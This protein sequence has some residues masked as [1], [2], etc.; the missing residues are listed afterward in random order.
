MRKQYWTVQIFYHKRPR[1]GHCLE[2][3]YDKKT[4]AIQDALN[5]R[6]LGHT[7]KINAGSDLPLFF[8][9]VRDEMQD[10]VEAPIP[11]APVKR[12]RKAKYI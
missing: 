5:W 12:G 6:Q 4:T 3:D 1:Q 10:E 2:L 9:N 11:S 8:F 7:V